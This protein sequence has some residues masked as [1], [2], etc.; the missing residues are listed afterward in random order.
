[1]KSQTLS[2]LTLLVVEDEPLIAMDI[3]VTLEDRGAKVTSTNSLKHASI[4]VEGD[5]LSGAIL[6]HSL[7]D[8]DSSILRKRLKER[9]I[10]FLV[11]SG[12]Q[13]EGEPYLS[14]PAT[15]DQLVH[16]LVKLIRNAG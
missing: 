4:L 6:D 2:G 5:G 13:I 14:K 7:G 15:P 10:P 16:A 3:T 9:A 11:H 1:M 8:G 12:F